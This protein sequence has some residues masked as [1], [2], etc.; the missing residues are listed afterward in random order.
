MNQEIINIYREKKE[1]ERLMQPY[2]AAIKIVKTKLEIIDQELRIKNEHSPIHNIQS[3]IKSLESII[4]KLERKELS[5][6]IEGIRKL[7]D[8]AGLRVICHYLN[9]FQKI[10]HQ[11]S[12]SPLCM[13]YFHFTR[14]TRKTQEK[15][16]RDG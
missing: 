4:E 15:P 14:F 12:Q 2:V 13:L 16:R 9:D 6:D 8:I 3:R 5:K 10:A 11:H 1:F 7:N